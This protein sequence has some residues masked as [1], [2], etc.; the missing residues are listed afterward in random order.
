M[1]RPRNGWQFSLAELMVLVTILAGTLS[2]MFA[3]PRWLAAPI[4]GVVTLILFGAM[5][6][7]VCWLVEDDENEK[8][9]V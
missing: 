8:D 5:C 4:L 6:L 1:P 9:G 2:A 3:M 7:A